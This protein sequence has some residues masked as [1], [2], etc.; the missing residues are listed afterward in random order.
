[1]GPVRKFAPALLLGGGFDETFYQSYLNEFPLQPGFEERLD[2]HNLYPLMVHVNL[3]GGNYVN[4]V[5][6]I[7]KKFN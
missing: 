6:S 3:F 7:L 4:Q 1:M 2:I 5:R